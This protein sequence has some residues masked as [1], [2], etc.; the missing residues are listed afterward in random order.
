MKLRLLIE[1]D[2]AIYVGT[3]NADMTPEIT[4]GW[5]ARILLD[6]SVDLFID[7]DPGARSLDNLERNG[8]IAVTF[9]SPTDYRSLQVKGVFLESGEPSDADLATVQ[10]HRDRFAAASAAL[11][12]PPHV[13][14]ALWTDAVV[15]I[16][17]QP[18]EAFDQTPGAGAGAPV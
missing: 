2:P 14:S 8:L 7:R 13:A 15:R 10:C 6:G 1:S 16:R 12:F 11:G 9:S 4:R 17:F 5:G 18:E 3:A